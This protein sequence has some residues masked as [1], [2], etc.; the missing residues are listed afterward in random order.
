MI[1]TIEAADLFCGAGGTSEGLMQAAKELG[2]KVNLLA[3]NHWNVAIATHS[4]NHPLAD[5]RCESLDNVDPRKAVPSGRLDLLCA[6]PECTHHSN[7]RGGKPMSDQSRASAWHV[8]RWCEALDIRNVLIENVPEFQFWGPLYED[9]NCGS[10]TEVDIKLHDKKCHWQRPVQKK[11]G[12]IY[13]AFL[14]SLRAL[15]Y[16]VNARVLNSANYGDPTTRERLFIMARKGK[17]IRWPEPTHRKEGNGDMFGELPKWKPAREIIDWNIKGDSIFTRASRGKKPLSPNTLKRIEAGLR[18]YSGMAFVLGQQSG[19]SPRSVDK[20]IP[21]I[22]GAGAISLIQPFII[23]MD[24][25][26]RLQDIEKPLNT[27]TSADSRG[28]VEPFLVEYHGTIGRQERTRS[29]DQPMPT[30]DTSN[31]FGLVE[32]FMVML[33]G[34]DEGSLENSNRSVDQPLPTITGSPHIGLAEPFIVPVNHGFG[35]TRTHSVDKPM[36]TITAFD[37]LALAQPFLVEYY[38]TSGAASVEDPLSTITGRDRFGLVEPTIF[39]ADDG[40]EYQLDIRFRML[41][42]HELA[43]AMSFP[44][45]YKF[46]GNREQQVKQIGNAVPVST[47]SALCQ[48]LL[49]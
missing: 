24:M 25:G 2:Y 4:T 47:A 16:S 39:Q 21:T 49:Q 46:T 34:T 17:A 5:T 31:R 8:L 27:L 18:K 10:G 30:L 45:G 20:P 28:L 9:C 6:S 38:G 14:S 40:K 1:R 29:L 36:P 22:A 19:A 35:D 12:R 44:A 7:A 13:R 48:A 43:A 26:G 42:P 3:I 15:G 32:P 41:Q 23:Q 33:N 11:K 37:A